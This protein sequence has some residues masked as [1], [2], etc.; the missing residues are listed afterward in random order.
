M[1]RDEPESVGENGP[2][3]T[4]SQDPIV[5]FDG[6]CGLCNSAVDWLLR[7]DRRGELKFAPIQGETAQRM[8]P[9][10][11][12]EPEAWSI[13]YVGPEGI[14]T[15]SN[16]AI[17]IARRLGGAW[18]ALAWVAI[19]PRPLRDLVYRFIARNRYRW[20]GKLD[21]CRLPSPEERARFLP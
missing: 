3:S 6:V 19:I 9:P 10:F 5:F 11:G 1:T 2:R 17:A 18:S 21:T 15:H 14:K 12:D 16:A 20:F 8:L 4:E 7:V 13:Y